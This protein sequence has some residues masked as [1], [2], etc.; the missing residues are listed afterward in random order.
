MI[1]HVTDGAY[2][3]ASAETGIEFYVDRLRRERNELIGE[4]SV[5]AGMLSASR[6]IDGVLSAGTFNISSPYSRSQRAKI[7]AERS[8]T[9][10]KVD[11][12]GMLE[13]V[14][15]RILNAERTGTPAIV[16]RDLPRPEADEA[17]NVDDFVFP[18]KHGTI[19]FGDGGTMKSY[20]AL[21]VVG[22]LAE[23]G[24]RVAL[25]D[26]EL[27]AAQHR[28]RL[29]RIF[30]A[31]TMPEVQYVRCDRPLVFE[32]DRLAQVARREALDFCLFDSAG[33]ACAGRPEDAEHA[34]AYFRA[35]RQI[36]TGSL[37]IAHI[38]KGDQADQKPFGSSFWHNSA[39]STW[40]VKLAA[41][42]AD[43]QVST[44]GLFNRKVNLGAKAPEI[45]FDVVFG[46][47]TT[48]FERI[49]VADVDELA[50]DLPLWRRM[51]RALAQGP[52]TLV[53][54]SEQ[55]GAKVDTIERTARRKS[56]VFTRV[57]DAADRIARIDLVNR[58]SA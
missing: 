18:R 54:L 43:G 36:G 47:N 27:D 48:R 33:Y 55:L 56:L 20:F 7:L 32:V 57:T 5:S 51:K 28:V 35:V 26:W 40:Y 15:Q 38:S 25:F 45:G 9:N 4:L 50:D 31:D 13:E 44:I 23:V 6:A 11:W 41:T 42:S 22:R 21:Y 34:L 1:F 53:S 39:R 37:H 2:S 8:R 46:T 19:L 3:C 29:E 58:R 30:G 49:D 17:H 16:L 10:G 12:H 14:C 24:W 52:L